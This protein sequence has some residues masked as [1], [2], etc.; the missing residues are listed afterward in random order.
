M[1]HALQACTGLLLC[2]PRADALERP[3]PG[4]APLWE[5][6][7]V[8]ASRLHF[9]MSMLGPCVPRLPQ[10]CRP[11]PHQPHQLPCTKLALSRY[12]F[13]KT[14]SHQ[15]RQPCETHRGPHPGARLRVIVYP[16]NSGPGLGLAAG[17]GAGGGLPGGAAAA[18]AAPSL[19]PSAEGSCV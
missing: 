6:D 13:V 9:L 2:L 18:A 8:L 10:V 17:P 15:A 16:G 3:G 12:A 11:S 19:E 7:A 14:L 4:G 1:D 5:A